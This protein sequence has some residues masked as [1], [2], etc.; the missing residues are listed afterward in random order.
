MIVFI[1]VAF[2]PPSH[3]PAVKEYH[4]F[5]VAVAFDYFGEASCL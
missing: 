5:S 1:R 2:Y 3:L 4:A